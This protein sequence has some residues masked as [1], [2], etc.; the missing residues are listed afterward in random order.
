MRPPALLH[1]KR[2]FPP[3]L[4]NAIYSPNLTA[5][6]LGFFSGFFPSKGIVLTKPP[7]FALKM[8]LGNL[9]FGVSSFYL[10]IF[11]FNF[12]FLF[13]KRPILV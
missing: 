13:R 3:V 12:L 2:T 6:E 10:F 8:D 11:L 5:R 9:G 4:L 7:S 1:V